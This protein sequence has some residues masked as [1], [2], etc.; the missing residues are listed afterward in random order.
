MRVARIG[1]ALAAAC[2][3]ACAVACSDSSAPGHGTPASLEIVSGNSQ[4]GI[5]G[6]ELSSPIVIRVR[7]DQ[8][9]AAPNAGVHVDVGASGSS[10]ENPDLVS[11]DSGLVLVRWTLG[12]V[13]QK[14]QISVRLAEGTASIVV[15]ATAGAGPTAGLRVTNSPLATTRNGDSIPQ[16]PTVAVVDRFGNATPDP[17]VLVS[18]SVAPSTA[19]RTLRGNIAATTNGAGVATFAG[20][21]VAGDT[22]TV[23]LLFSAQG[24][25]SGSATVLLT[26]G[27]PS[28]IVLVGNGVSATVFDNGPP[29][30]VRV[31][32][33]S[34]NG[35][36]GIAVQF[37]FPSLAA[38]VTAQSD[39]SGIA[40]L[41]AWIVPPTAGTYSMVASVT[42]V[43]DLIIAV[44]AK[45]RPPSKLL[46]ITAAS[47]A[48][49]AGDVTSD[50]SVRAVDPVGNEVGGVTVTFALDGALVKD[51][52]TDGE[53]LAT[54][55]AWKLP[56]LPAGYHLTA[57]VVG[58]PSVSFD[59][60]V[61]LGPASKLD[62]LVS[63]T[64]PTV[65]TSSQIT[66]RVTDA[67]GNIVINSPVQWQALTPG[68][69][70]TPASTMSDSSGTVNVV[71][72]FS[73]VATTVRFRASLAGGTARDFSYTLA[74]GPM[75]AFETPVVFLAF[76]VN[77]RFTVAVKALDQW[78][79]PVPNA[80]IS[81]YVNFP[82]PYPA[83]APA[84]IA[85]DAG[86]RAT[87]SGVTGSAPGL[88]EF[89]LYGGILG[90]TATVRVTVF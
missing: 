16:A 50:I 75:V 81:S 65:A 19:K 77:T 34:G 32:D 58:L 60:T 6:A 26:P 88:E 73:T 68:V 15:D 28:S 10:V 87:L 9:H 56:S 44:T 86:G 76:A 3:V 24:L 42:G 61:S 43:P 40:T 21:V 35:L 8:D 71:V 1:V 54:L 52:I 7:D 25:A 70:V 29:V 57:T 82:S 83:L 22:G 27:A 63:P 47:I 74:P 31:V 59:V 30:Q 17:N 90:A 12:T 37:A 48:G 78:G 45:P 39:V 67:A 36:R 55:S 13:A 5:V 41:S 69:S 66:A 85:T 49:N 89:I 18:A 4:T 72:N 46:P 51:V 20:L 80:T 11:N 23:G 14:Q 53:G 84:T 33:E 38:P 79:N 2:A 62:L 64:I